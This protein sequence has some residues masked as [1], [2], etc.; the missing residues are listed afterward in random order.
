M[1]HSQYRKAVSSPPCHTAPIVVFIHGFLGSGEDWQAARSYLSQY[2]SISI[3][4]P[5]HGKSKS[6][7]CLGFD[8]ACQMIE[9]TLH[10]ALISNGESA[11][12]PLVL[13]GYSLGARLLMYGLSTS[14]F[15]TLNLA[16]CV[17]EGGNFGLRSDE[18][19]KKRYKAD[20][21][22]AKRFESEPI[23]QVLDDWYHQDVFSSLN[24]EQ[25]QYLVTKRSG[26]L[27]NA[28]ANMLMATSLSKQPN[29]LES[30]QALRFKQGITVLYLCGKHDTKFRTLAEQSQ[31]NYQV[32]GNAGHNVHVE[33]PQ[34]FALRLESYI[35]K[36]SL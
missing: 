14:Q 16:G 1:L 22:W 29:L 2:T 10:H 26:N 25:R 12:A 8:D 32:V 17:I 31:L 27:G 9:K 20:E 21:R 7:T 13:V 11:S 30:I 35:E 33:Q 15:N 36:M 23:A 5:C 19:R 34:Q 28:L 6:M 3:D 4:L 24:N 18:L